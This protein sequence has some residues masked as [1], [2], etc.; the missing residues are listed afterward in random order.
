MPM[1]LV[2]H[3]Y[4]EHADDTRPRRSIAGQAKLGALVLVASLLVLFIALNFQN[5]EVNLLVTKQ[6]IRLALALIL[7]ALL[8]LL[9]GLLTPRRY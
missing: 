6:D 8:G 5:V 1:L 3:R 2:V 4:S 7:A 9:A